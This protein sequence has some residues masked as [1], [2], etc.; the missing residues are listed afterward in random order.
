[1]LAQADLFGHVDGQ[2]TKTPGERCDGYRS[3]LTGCCLAPLE[4]GSA[5]TVAN[6]PRVSQSSGIPWRQRPLTP[7]RTAAEL[8]GVS[9]TTL[10]RLEA[11]GRLHFGRINGK[12]LVK[13]ESLVRLVD[14]VDDWRPGENTHARAVV[15]RSA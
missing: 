5:M 11:E 8:A 4:K 9:R 14:N 3:R 10:Y 1:M 7:L 6:A 13:T 15:A 12:V 2:T